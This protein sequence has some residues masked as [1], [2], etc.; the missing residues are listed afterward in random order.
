MFLK[1]DYPD[2]RSFEGTSRSVADPRPS[3]SRQW[4]GS[5]GNARHLLFE[6][7]LH[8][9]GLGAHLVEK[10]LVDASKPE[11]PFPGESEEGF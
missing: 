5:K 11:D 10:V 2:S 8:H 3:G 7:K 6:Y 1:I 9:T 4:N